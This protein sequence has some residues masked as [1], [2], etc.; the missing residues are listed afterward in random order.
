MTLSDW[1]YVCSD[2]IVAS[3]L[4]RIY[5][6]DDPLWQTIEELSWESGINPFIARPIAM[7]WSSFKN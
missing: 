7:N 2:L 5:Q 3:P 1:F 6:V 4:A